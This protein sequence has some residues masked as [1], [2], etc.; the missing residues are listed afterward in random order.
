[1]LVERTRLAVSAAIRSSF[2]HRGPAS[3]DTGHA[4]RSLARPFRAHAGGS[5]PASRPDGT[6]LGFAPLQRLRNRRSGST[7]T[8]RR[9][10]RLRDAGFHTRHLPSSAF[11]TPSTA[12]SLQPRPGLFHP[13]NAHGV[14]SS[15]LCSTPVVR[16]SLEAGC[17]L[18]VEVTLSPAAKRSRQPSTS[19]LCSHRSVRTAT[20]RNPRAAVALLTL[21]PLRLSLSPR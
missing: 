2:S 12:Y 19:E 3:V 9:V 11:R 15:G 4:S 1:V 5:T 8:F 13:G 14:P 10:C 7:R 16:T 17:S 21:F 6:L 20:G 18:A